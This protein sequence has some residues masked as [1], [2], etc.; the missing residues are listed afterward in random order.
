[1]RRPRNLVRRGGWYYARM[2][3]GGKLYR[4]A[5]GTR[6]SE[7]ARD[8]LAASLDAIELEHRKANEPRTETVSTF[9]TRWMK[10]W[11]HQR[12][13]PKGVKLTERRLEQ[14]ILPVI[15]AVELARLTYADLRALRARL[16]GNMEPQTVHHIL[17]DVRCLLRHAVDA[18]ELVSV[19]WRRDI[20]PRIAEHAPRRL[21]DEQME[22]IFNYAR[23]KEALC[24]GLVVETGLRWGELRELQWRHVVKEPRLHLVLEGTKSGR[25]RRVPLTAE[26][27]RVIEELRKI[28]SGVFVSPYRMVNPCTLAYRNAGRMPEDNKVNWHWHQ[29]RHTFACRYLERG[30]SLAA[31]QRMLGH[32]TSRMTERY[33]GLSDAALFADLDRVETGPVSGPNG[34]SENT[35][36]RVVNR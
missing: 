29:L 11:V 19:P 35:S 8:C 26:A 6:D 34:R 12:R 23:P 18:G 31:L 21:A 17:S 25:V 14:H 16:D 33:A 36:M 1:M 4:R 2:F 30:G 13:N 7:T 10:E 32:S 9:S 3:V 5:L 20:M 22:Q 24:I 28:A 15:G 27:G